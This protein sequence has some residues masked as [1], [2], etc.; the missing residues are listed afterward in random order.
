VV[1]NISM[2]L[3]ILFDLFVGVFPST[4]LKSCEL[5]LQSIQHDLNI[6]VRSFVCL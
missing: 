4:S 3:A 5:Y 6:Q 2:A 1:D